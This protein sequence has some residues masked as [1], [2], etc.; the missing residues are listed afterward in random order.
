MFSISVATAESSE[1]ADIL[2][3]ALEQHHLLGFEVAQMNFY[4]LH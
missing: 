3:V 4:H 1:F 2:S